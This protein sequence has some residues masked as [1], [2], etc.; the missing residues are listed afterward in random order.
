MDISI[1]LSLQSFRNG[2]GAC[3][4]DF[5]DQMTFFG[6]NS[7]IAIALALLY[8]CVNKELGVYLLMGYC[9]N[10]FVNSLLKVTFCVYRP[11]I[12]SAAIIPYADAQASATGYSFPS[13]H[14]ANATTVYGGSALRRE[15]PRMLRVLFFVIVALVALSRMFL[16]VHTPQDVLVSFGVGIAVMWCVLKLTQWLQRRPEK[17]VTVA[18]IAVALFIL[19]GLYAAFKSYPEDY[20]SQGKLIVDGAKMANDTFKGVGWGLAFFLGWALERRFVRFSTEIAWTQKIARCVTGALGYYA[21]VLILLPILKSAVPGYWGTILTCFIQMFYVTY[22]FP[23]S[24][25]YW[26]KPNA[27]GR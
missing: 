5:L 14:T 23:A 13:G 8:W 6:E 12:R 20:D 11:W 16:G 19:L 27:T 18:V 4:T 3:L 10:R 2:A 21:I 24:L 9:G 22:L 7:F 26:E 15:F 17:D 1:L 25:K